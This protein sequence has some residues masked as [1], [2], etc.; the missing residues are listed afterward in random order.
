MQRVGWEVIFC[1][2]PPALRSLLRLESEHVN[3]ASESKCMQC[4]VS[5]F[6]HIVQIDTLGRHIPSE[7]GVPSDP[8][9]LTH[10]IPQAKRL[11]S[12]FVS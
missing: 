4:P 9:L 1:A 12:Q 8:P 2:S 7:L 3:A 5:S 6:K 11:L 10:R